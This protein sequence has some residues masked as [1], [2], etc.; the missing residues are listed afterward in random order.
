MVVAGPRRVGDHLL[1]IPHDGF[2]FEVRLIQVRHA[3]RRVVVL[4]AAGDR[5]LHNEMRAEHLLKR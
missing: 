5:Y 1:G 3:V 2:G 4:V